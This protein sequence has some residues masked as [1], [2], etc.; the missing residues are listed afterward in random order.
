VSHVEQLALS[1]CAVKA[2]GSCGVALVTIHMTNRRNPIATITP[3]ASDATRRRYAAP[4]P[5][6]TAELYQMPYAAP[7]DERRRAHRIHGSSHRAGSCAGFPASGEIVAWREPAANVAP[8]TSDWRIFSSGTR[9]I[10][11]PHGCRFPPAN[12]CLRIPARRSGGTHKFR[13]GHPAQGAQSK[14]RAS[15]GRA[16]ALEPNYAPYRIN[17]ATAWKES[18]RF[19]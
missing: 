12:R 4:H 14:R 1:R 11:F 16:L 19:I 17:A 6:A 2:P 3:G 15:H 13:V 7:P 9:R 10:R 5:A 8:R 18:R